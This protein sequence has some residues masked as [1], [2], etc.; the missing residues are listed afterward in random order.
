M[1]V[2][3][4]T[5]NQSCGLYRVPLPGRAEVERLVTFP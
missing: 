3:D 5:N 2:P 1:T 4:I